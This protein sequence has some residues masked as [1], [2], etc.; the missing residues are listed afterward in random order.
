MFINAFVDFDLRL[1]QLGDCIENGKLI[2]ILRDH[3][4]EHFEFLFFEAAETRVELVGDLEVGVFLAR[5]HVLNVGFAKG[6]FLNQVPEV[7]LEGFFAVVQ[8]RVFLQVHDLLRRNV[9]AHDRL[10]VEVFLS[11]KDLV[12]AALVEVACL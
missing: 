4:L 1:L 5:E 3:L 9:F 8:L 11:K 2:I 10:S 12:Q 6:K 7:H